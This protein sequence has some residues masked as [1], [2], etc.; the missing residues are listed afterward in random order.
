[1]REIQISSQLEDLKDTCLSEDVKRRYSDRLKQYILAVLR[2]EFDESSY[3]DQMKAKSKIAD[4]L[5]LIEEIYQHPAFSFQCE[6][7]APTCAKEVIHI[8]DRYN[9]V[10]EYR[11]DCVAGIQLFKQALLLSDCGNCKDLYLL[12]DFNTPIIRDDEIYQVIPS[13]YLT[14]LQRN[15]N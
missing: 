4:A 2:G 5:A 1:M 13:E 6:A 14:G 12:L 3:L 8:L 9:E 11:F 7:E 10:V 15:N